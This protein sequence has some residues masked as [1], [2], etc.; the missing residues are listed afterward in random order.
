MQLADKVDV[1]KIGYSSRLYQLTRYYE[2]RSNDTAVFVHP[3]MATKIR[4][5]DRSAY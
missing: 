2:C 3:K 1:S 4:P 5:Q